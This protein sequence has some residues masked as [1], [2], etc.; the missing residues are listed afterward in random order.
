ML[1][2]EPKHSAVQ[3]T[4]PCPRHL[5]EK[6]RT[7]VWGAIL[8]LCCFRCTTGQAQAILPVAAATLALDALQAQLPGALYH[9]ARCEHQ[10]PLCPPLILPATCL[11]GLGG[12]QTLS[13]PFRW[14]SESLPAFP[15]LPPCRISLVWPKIPLAEVLLSAWLTG[16]GLRH[17]RE[18]VPPIPHELAKEGS[19]LAQAAVSFSHIHFWASLFLYTA[20]FPGSEIPHNPRKPSIPSPPA[21]ASPAARSFVLS[22]CS[23]CQRPKQHGSLQ[24]LSVPHAP[25]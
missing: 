4:C 20:A 10:V 13:L 12:C 7:Y 16:M 1:C 3:A 6:E 23:C 14:G 21:S 9:K 15:S 18:S 11:V 22:G 5:W 17:C 24:C 2:R 8:G 19:W 25:L